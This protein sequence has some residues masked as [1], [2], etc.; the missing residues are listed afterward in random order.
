MEGS[1]DEAIE[2]L[3]WD[4]EHFGL[5][6]ARVCDPSGPEQMHAAVEVADRTG[7][8][9]LTALV[10]ADRVE[11]I[12]AAEDL[13]FRCY[14]IRTAFDRKIDKAPKVLADLD[15]RLIAEADLPHLEPIARERFSTTRFVADPHF[16]R[17]LAGSLYVEW[18]RRGYRDE[19]RFVIAPNRLDGFVACHLESKRGVGV[20]ELIAVASSSEGSGL[21]GRLIEGAEALFVNEGLER[22]H[23]VTQGR[24]LLAQK[25]YQSYGYRTEDISLWFHRWAD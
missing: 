8:R 20:I 13:S 22:A 6:V 11:T 7:V 24:N 5:P 23:V 21:G 1:P 19:S 12:T 25:L 16:P 9:C 10:K 2:F 17:D 18:L 14:D 3:Q 15:L 4:S